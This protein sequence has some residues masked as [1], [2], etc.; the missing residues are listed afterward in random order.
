[1]YADSRQ[2]LKFSAKL[3]ICG[4]DYIEVDASLV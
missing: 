3:M 1:M 2:G 4:A